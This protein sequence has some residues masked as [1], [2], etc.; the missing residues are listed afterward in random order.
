MRNLPVMGADGRGHLS[1]MLLGGTSDHIL[2]HATIPL[3][4]AH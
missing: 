2:K 1:E 3:L 4:L